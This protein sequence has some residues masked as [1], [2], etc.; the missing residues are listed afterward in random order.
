M[1]GPD[2]RRGGPRRSGPMMVSTRWVNIAVILLV[3]GGLI[4][5][6][7]DRTLPAG[8]YFHDLH[9]KYF[10]CNYGTPVVPVGAWVG[11]WHDGS[12]EAHECMRARRDAAGH[13][14]D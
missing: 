7:G 11:T 12:P 4:V 2:R 9:H 1:Q 14:S 8:D 6:V 3:V 5:V 10:E 13:T